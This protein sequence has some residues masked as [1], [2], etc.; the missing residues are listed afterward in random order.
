MAE[1]ARVR[2]PKSPGLSC[3]L[4]HRPCPGAPVITVGLHITI[5]AS[6]LCRHV[7][8]SLKSGAWDGRGGAH[9]GHQG[10]RRQ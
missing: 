6:L 4:R 9:A 8:G 7:G 2:T 3:S 10:E 5:R 1:A